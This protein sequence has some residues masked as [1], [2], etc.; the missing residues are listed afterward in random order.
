MLALPRLM[1]LPSMAA[2]AREEKRVKRSKVGSSKKL[3]RL[4]MKT[5]GSKLAKRKEGGSSKDGGGGKAKKRRRRE[6]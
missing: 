1:T 3:R 5:A 4:A 6:E 2:V